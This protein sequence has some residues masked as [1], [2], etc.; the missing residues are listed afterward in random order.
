MKTFTVEQSQQLEEVLKQRYQQ[1][2]DEVRAE[3][4]GSGEQH[5]ADFAESGGSDEGDESM[6]DALADI[7]AAR[8]DRQI[9]EMRDIEAARKR[10]KQGEFGICIDCAEAIVIARLLAY[11]TALRCVRC[12]QIHEKTHASEGTP[13]L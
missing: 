1:L 5:F 4:A 12:Q 10:L 3:L 11:P 6:A 7:A 9:N 8:A 2:L 13:S